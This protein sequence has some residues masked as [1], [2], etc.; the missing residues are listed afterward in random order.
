[1]ERIKR[2]LSSALLNAGYLVSRSHTTAGSIKTSASREVIHDI[3]RSF[4]KGHPV[5]MTNIKDNSPARKL[6]STIVKY[7]CSY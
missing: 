2:V 5:K 3:F 1:M 7:K 6:L 4:I